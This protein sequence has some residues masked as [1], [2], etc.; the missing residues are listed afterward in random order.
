MALLLTATMSMVSPL[1]GEALV[2]HK[3]PDL[4][5]GGHILVNGRPPGWI[6]PPEVG[7]EPSQ[8]AE[9][10]SD[11]P[12][13]GSKPPDSPKQA[14][15]SGWGGSVEEWRPLVSAYFAP[16][17]VETAMCIM[18]H[19]SGGN[20]NA[21]N[22]N[23]TASGLFQMLAMWHDYFGIDPFVPEQ[24]V[25]A[26]AQLKALYGWSQWSPYQRGECRGL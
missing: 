12:E 24:N 16:G 7:P 19:E 14:P 21:K 22:P 25:S 2:D 26:A 9:V 4:P 6:A 20:P 10:A 17:D 5:A 11:G 13:R 23:S 15:S 1:A 8:T 3:P 18:S